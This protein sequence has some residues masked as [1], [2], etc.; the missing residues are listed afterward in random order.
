MTFK[1]NKNCFDNALI[2]ENY[3]WG[4]KLK[5]KRKYWVET[6]PKK[7]DRVCFQTLNPKTNK[8]CKVK[9]ST[10]SHVAVLTEKNGYVSHREIGNWGGWKSF[11]DSDIDYE[12]LNDE[13]KKKLCE[14][15]AIDEVM[16]NVKIEIKI[17]QPGSEEEEKKQEEIKVKIVGAVN[18]KINACFKKQQLI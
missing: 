17:N 13:Q 15:K 4:Y 5:T 14:L 18:Y 10:Y 7:G 1:Y 9:K 3:P 8:W 12:K 16:K 2:V 11:L 6:I